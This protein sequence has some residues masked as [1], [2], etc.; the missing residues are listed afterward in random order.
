[1]TDTYAVERF[2]ET[3][4]IDSYREAA[5]DSDGLITGLDMFNGYTVQVIFENQDFGE[6]LVVDGEITVE[7][8]LGLAGDAFVGLLYDVDILPMFPFYDT[9][10]APFMKNVSR[11]YVDYYQSLDFNINGKL[12]PYQSFSDI[13]QG[14]PLQPQTGTAIIAPVSGWS[15][16]DNEML[17]ITQSSPFDLQ[18]L[19]IGYQI[20]MAVL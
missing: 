9:A 3:I 11:V 19:S 8:P 17:R 18:I 2:D 16:F 5:M 13:Q 14:L 1:L 15:R 7:N 6:Y 20:E 4:K 12:I 10:A